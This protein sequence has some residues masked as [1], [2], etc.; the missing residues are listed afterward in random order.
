MPETA[1]S[2]DGAWVRHRRLSKRFA[3]LS[4]RTTLVALAAGTGKSTLTVLLNEALSRKV[5][6]M[7]FIEHHIRRLPTSVHYNAE[8]LRNFLGFP[9]P[10]VL[11]FADASAPPN[12]QALREILRSSG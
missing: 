4:Q 11:Y 3:A 1:A 10:D 8:E 5:D 9:P 12:W 6:P 7:R 2:N